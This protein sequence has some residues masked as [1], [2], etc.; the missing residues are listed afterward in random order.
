VCRTGV[1]TG[2][3]VAG[4][5]L[6]TVSYGGAARFCRLRA[7]HGG[8]C[9]GKTS[10]GL[11]RAR[12]LGPR[13][14]DGRGRVGTRGQPRRPFGDRRVDARLGGGLSLD[15]ETGKAGVVVTP[16]VPLLFNSGG[17]QAGQYPGGFRTLTQPFEDPLFGTIVLVGVAH[18]SAPV[19]AEFD[20]VVRNATTGETIV[21]VP[22]IRVDNLELEG[23]QFSADPTEHCDE[24]SETRGTVFQITLAPTVNEV[25]VGPTDN[26]QLELLPTAVFGGE[27]ELCV[28]HPQYSGMSLVVEPITPPNQPPVAVADSATTPKNT[29]VAIPV[30]PSWSSYA[31]RWPR[32][33]VREERRTSPSSMAVA[34][35][36]FTATAVDPPATAEE[37]ARLAPSVQPPLASQTW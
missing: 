8:I 2:D 24:L 35:A 17:Q 27:M 19:S 5:R 28:D 3:S 26:L 10:Y 9:N 11:E 30:L 18:N 20:A 6:R 32:G 1:S 23:S 36:G 37:L 14:G 31:W 13:H 33:E 29:A 25:I 34:C 21:T 16:G 22:G 4:R 7:H 15:F 12:V